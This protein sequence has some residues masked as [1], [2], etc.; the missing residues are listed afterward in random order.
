MAS[1]RLSP[2]SG[3]FRVI[4]LGR[5]SACETAPTG[6]PIRS[7]AVFAGFIVVASCLVALRRRFATAPARSLRQ[8]RR[9][10]ADRSQACGD[11]SQPIREIG[12]TSGRQS[13]L[14]GERNRRCPQHRLTDGLEG[15]GGVLVTGRVLA[16]E[17]AIASTSF[18]A[19]TQSTRTWSRISGIRGAV[20]RMRISRAV[21][22]SDGML[23]HVDTRPPR[24]LARPLSPS[25]GRSRACSSLI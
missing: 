2:Y 23:D 14:V 13:H 5:F 24:A 9:G 4:E 11:A 25:Y 16:L 3:A 17:P 1:S 18:N 10:R 20:S 12:S 19:S 7:K 21:G 15:G 22:G 8:H 6:L